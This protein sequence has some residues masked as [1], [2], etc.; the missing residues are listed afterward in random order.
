MASPGGFAS[1]E[2]AIENGYMDLDSVITYRRRAW[3]P[4]ADSPATRVR[5]AVRNHADIVEEHRRASEGPSTW[6][7]DVTGTSFRVDAPRRQSTA[8]RRR[9]AGSLQIVDGTA[10][11]G[12]SRSSTTLVFRERGL[13]MRS[14]RMG[15]KSAR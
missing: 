3:R 5:M 1:G 10:W 11:D 7:T 9:T 15:G 14:M 4:Q 2:I 6:W 13:R 12:R 8:R